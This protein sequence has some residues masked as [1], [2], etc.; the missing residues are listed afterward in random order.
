MTSD[1]LNAALIRDARAGLS[2]AQRAL[3]ERY[4]ETVYRL[5][6]SATGDPEEAFDIALHGIA[7][8]LGKGI[9]IAGGLQQRVPFIAIPRRRWQ[10]RLDH[11]CHGQRQQ[12][13]GGHALGTQESPQPALLAPRQAPDQPQHGHILPG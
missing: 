9:G 7:I 11:R 8:L 2:G 3:V 13:H 4:R 1:T 10:Q 12:R 5:A 6:R